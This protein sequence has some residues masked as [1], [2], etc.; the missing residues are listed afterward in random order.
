MTADAKVGLLLGLLFIVLIAFL[1][2]GFPPFLKSA[3]AEDVV[4]T[5]SLT[6]PSGPAM[7]IDHGVTETAQRLGNGVPLRVTEA[8]QEVIILGGSSTPTVV[9]PDIITP[10]VPQPAPTVIV[11]QPRQLPQPTPAAAAVREHTVQRG[12]TLASIAQKYYGPEEGNRRAVVQ[13]LY[14]ANQDVMSS[15]DRIIAGSTLTI[16]PLPGTS[17]AAPAAPAAATPTGTLLQ[18]FSNMFERIASPPQTTRAPGAA[19]PRTTEYVVQPGDSLWKIAEKTLGDG[20]RFQ[21]LV[22]MN[23]DRLKSPDDVIVG[24]KLIVPVP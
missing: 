9:P 12:E 14:E 6:P 17:S 11:E 5:T 8:P 19:Q 22:E 15:P 18:R 21:T 7:V 10:A 1:I 13:F 24:M 2:N 20:R 16:P 23:Q 4:K 3:A